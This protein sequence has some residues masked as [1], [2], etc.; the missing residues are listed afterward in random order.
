MSDAEIEMKMDREH[1][2]RWM[3]GDVHA[4]RFCEQFLHLCHW[5]DDAVDGDVQ[6]SREDGETMTWLALVDLPSN[7]FYNQHHAQL[8]PVITAAV[9]DWLT[10][11]TLEQGD[12][13]E[14][15]VA[16]TLRC[17]IL[18]VVAHCA[19]LIGGPVW[20]RQ[21][22]LEIRRYGHRETLEQYLEDL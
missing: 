18:T 19:L 8:Q 16:Y 15:T 10:A 22:G 4:V 3:Q 17:S 7:T 5:L 21:A 14:R 11:N 12:A 9:A 1:L 13:H 6:R 2:M 20:A